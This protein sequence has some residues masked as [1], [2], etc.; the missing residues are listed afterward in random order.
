MLTNR[1]NNA[2]IGLMRAYPVDVLKGKISFLHYFADSTCHERNGI[3][4][5][6]LA[7]LMN[8]MHTCIYSLVTWNIS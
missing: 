2:L 7:I 6:I 8:E 4:E 1:I 3:L 5:N